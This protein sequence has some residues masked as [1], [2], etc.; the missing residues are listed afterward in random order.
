VELGGTW[1]SP[2]HKATLHLVELLELSVYNASFLST[3]NHHGN[4]SHDDDDD[5]S[6][7][8][9]SEFPWWWWG[10]DYSSNEMQRLQQTV[11]HLHQDRNA[12]QNHHRRVLFSNPQ[13][14]HEAFDEQTLSELEIAGQM[15]AKD[16]TSILVTPAGNQQ[17]E[18]GENDNNHGDGK[19]LVWDIPTPG[20]TWKELDSISTTQRFLQGNAKQPSPSSPSPSETDSSRSNNN[21]KD[22]VASSSTTSSSKTAPVLTTVNSR[23]IL[24]N[25]IHNKNAQEPHYVS[26]LYNLI[27]WGGNNSGHGPDTQFRVRGGTQAIPLMIAKKLTRTTNLNRER[28]HD[29]FNSNHHRQY[30]YKILL[31]SPVTKIHQQEET[32]L[33]RTDSSSTKSTSVAVVT[34]QNGRSFRAAVGVILTGSPSAVQ[35]FIKLES[36]SSTSPQTDLLVGSTQPETEILESGAETKPIISVPPHNKMPMGCCIKFM[37]VFNRRG[38]WWR[39]TKYNLQG[40]ILSCYLPQ[41]LSLPIQQS[42]GSS[43]FA[44]IFPYCFDVSPFSQN[45]GVL[46]C[47]LE[48]DFVY[49]HFRSLNR[50]KQE[51]LLQEFLCLSFQGIVGDSQQVPPLWQPDY[52]VLHDWGTDT[53]PYVGG[54]YTSYFPPNILSQEK[55]W[56]AYHDMANIMPPNVYLAGSDYHCGFGNGYIEGAIRSGQ[57]AADHIFERRSER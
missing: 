49:N 14:F 55:Y 48:G 23:N 10:V 33:G 46:C 38:Q 8:E 52:F 47:F 24:R 7:G 40:D 22:A 15:I 19:K 17:N 6:T 26:Y 51:A 36:S 9:S 4:D 12:D 39:N 37:A 28:K 42:D 5:K 2:S 11:L 16:C 43:E 30:R 27:S 54:A 20:A 29:E 1:I 53:E 31:N 44:P 34:I 13:E 18:K 35:R 56:Q 25:C 57:N 41:H 32:L 50:Q 3:K 21:D 45:D